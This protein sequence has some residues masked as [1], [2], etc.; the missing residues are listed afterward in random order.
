MRVGFIGLGFMGHGMA[1]NILKRG[2]PLTVM[3]H[4]KREA[5]EDLVA[6]GA[7]EVRGAA[8][9]A[10]ACDVI[11]LCV[12]GAPEVE[13]NV[14]DI[15]GAKRPLIV[16]DCTT[17]N[18]ATL[19]RLAKDYSHLT[20]VD[21]P[22]GRSPKEAW[23]GTLAV[24]VGAEAAVLE[25]IRPMLA[26][27]AT[28]IQHVGGLGDG[29]RLKLVNNLVSMGFAALYAEA[30]VLA[31]KV[32]LG[33]EAFDGLIRSSRMHCAFYDSYM[34]WALDGNK[35]AHP[36]ALGTAD[37]TVADVDALVRD[38]GMKSPLTEALRQTYQAAVAAGYATAMLAELPRFVAEAN[39]LELKPLSDRHSRA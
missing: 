33:T 3:A 14:I 11:L 29:H 1:A 17:S 21:A 34:G 26:A 20:F 24:M 31:N 27:F 35:N 32:G 13:R 30:L 37:H 23:A 8:E 16:V 39:G 22:L 19:L 18:P 36:F 10:A 6:K 25:Q 7:V 28:T 38:A 5:V 15:A 9:M 2:F 4:R 12:T